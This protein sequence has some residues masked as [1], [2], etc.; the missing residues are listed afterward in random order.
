MAQAILVRR[1]IVEEV[2]EQ[3]G[4]R[5]E[6]ITARFFVSYGPV[7][8]EESKPSGPLA[9]RLDGEARPFDEI[10]SRR[11]VQDDASPPTFESRFRS[12]EHRHVETGVP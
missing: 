8:I 9:D 5:R 2:A 12:L 3:R 6:P 11:F 10:T 1:Q 4:P 7:P